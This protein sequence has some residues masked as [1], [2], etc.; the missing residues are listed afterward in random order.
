VLSFEEICDKNAYQNSQLIPVTQQRYN[1]RRLYAINVLNYF[2][3]IIALLFHVYLQRYLRKKSL[4]LT[5]V[6]YYCSRI[7]CN[8]TTIMC[9][10]STVI[11]IHCV[12]LLLQ[13]TNT[14]FVSWLLNINIHSYIVT[15]KT[16]SFIHRRNSCNC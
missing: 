9:F 5:P 6:F 15:A 7:S 1:L 14:V 3:I 10:A 2:C 11:N 16:T 12:K 13:C 8:L 4:C